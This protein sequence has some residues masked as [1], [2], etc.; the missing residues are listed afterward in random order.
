MAYGTTIEANLDKGHGPIAT[1][2]VQNGTL[3]KGDYLVVGATY[4]KI[5]NMF[6]ENNNELQIA[7]PSKPVKVTGFDSVPIAG[8]KFLALDDEKQ[9]REIANDVKQK[10]IRIERA[11]TNNIDLKQKIADGEL[12]NINLIIKADVQGSLEALKGI[13]AGI[14]INGATSSLIRSAIG[15]ISESD[16]RLAQTSNAVIIGFNIRPSRLIKELADS[17]GIKIVSYEVIYKFKEDLE[18]WLK[19]S[20]D[21]VIVEEVIGEAVVLKIWHHSQ[22]GT[23]CGCNVTNGKI[24]RNALAR[25]I[26]DG[27]VIYSSK[28][29]SLQQAKDQASEVIKGRD[30]GLTIE[31][32]NDIKENDIIECYAKI[33]KK[34]D[35]VN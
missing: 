29:A 33:E 21:P 30:C 13:V 1:L 32:F 25:V 18:S 28:I 14:E 11:I 2:L 23:I 22:V 5:R 24:K 6:D 10:N 26:R 19:G 4:G 34:H 7:P 15:Q 16:I 9:A 27:A 8:D 35:E 20:L 12:K 3:K 31:N 17:V